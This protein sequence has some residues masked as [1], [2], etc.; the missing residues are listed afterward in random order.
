MDIGIGNGMRN[1][2]SA[3]LSVGDFDSARAYV[4]T[5]YVSLGTIVLSIMLLIVAL[6]GFV[7]FSYVFNTTAIDE[8]QLG[9]GVLIVVLTMVFNFL[10]SL[11]NS[12]LN[13]LQKNSFISLGLIIGNVLMVLFF[14]LFSNSIASASAFLFIAITYSFSIMGGAILLT[15]LTFKYNP[16]LRP[17]IHFFRREKIKSI[18]NLGVRFFILQIAFVVILTTDSFII[19]QLYGAAEVTPYYVTQKIFQIVTI[20]AGI[21]VQPL[22]S[23]TT[24]AFAK[25]DLQWIK[26]KLRFLF[27][28][29]G[30]YVLVVFAIILC[31]DGIKNIWVGTDVVV[32]SSLKWFMGLYVV[33]WFW[34]SIF[35]G[36]LNGLGILYVQLWESVLGIII[37][38]PLCIFFA[39]TLNMG[40]SG[41]VMGANVSYIISAIIFPYQTYLLLQNKAKGIWARK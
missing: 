27:K 25:G 5:A 20:L 28:I 26:N 1:K 40:L 14:L 6:F 29:F 38:I 36:V 3:A 39:K 41:I 10:L 17:S 7:D 8:Y 30:V 32:P 18:S 35:V 4:S 19:T 2:V 13:A 33:L 31:F 15:Y 37:N 16:K 23:A 12:V 9:L 11:A 22:W 24:E 21:I 34:N